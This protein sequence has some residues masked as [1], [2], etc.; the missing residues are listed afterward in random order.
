MQSLK[1]FKFSNEIVCKFDKLNYD[2]F[3]NDENERKS[4]KYVT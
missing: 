2:K 3:E 4:K 1:F